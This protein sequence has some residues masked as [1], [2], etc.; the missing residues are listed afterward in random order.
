[1]VKN[2]ITGGEDVKDLRGQSIVRVTCVDVKVTKSQDRNSVEESDTDLE[3]KSS[4]NKGEWPGVWKTTITK[5]VNVWF[6]LILGDST[7]VFLWMSEG[8]LSGNRNEE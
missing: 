3:L 5:K 4:G 8:E 1:M 6:S 7:Q 2:K